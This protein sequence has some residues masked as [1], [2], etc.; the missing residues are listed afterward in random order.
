MGWHGCNGMERNGMWDG[1]EWNGDE[2]WDEVGSDGVGWD[3]MGCSMVRWDG[4][5]I[6]DEV[7]TCQER[8]CCTRDS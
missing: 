8:T 1:M 5:G 6:G 7:A 3:G 4:V 2:L